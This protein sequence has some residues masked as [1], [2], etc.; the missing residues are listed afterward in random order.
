MPLAPIRGAPPGAPIPDFPRH[1]PQAAMVHPTAAAPTTAPHPPEAPAP[2]QSD[3]PVEIRCDETVLTFRVIPELPAIRRSSMVIE[4]GADP[5]EGHSPRVLAS[6]EL[7]PVQAERFL[8]EFR[9]G[10]SPIAIR[11]DAVTIECEF[12]ESGLVF[13]VRESGPGT[14]LRRFAVDRTFDARAMADRLLADL[15]TSG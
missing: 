9:N 15:G 2:R 10:H 7:S 3:A 14:A 6:F 4:V 12:T 11:G 8:A 1:P 5:T 13:T